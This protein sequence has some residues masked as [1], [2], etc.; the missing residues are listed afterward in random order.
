M[1]CIDGL[2]TIRMIR[3]KLKLSPDKQPVILLHSAS[4]D[5]ALHRQCDE[6]GV[7]FR[8][9]KPVKSNDLFSYLCNL[10]QPD[11]EIEKQEE[12]VQEVEASRTDH[13]AEKIKIL[14]AEDMAM[15]MLLVKAMLSRLVRNVD[16]IEA[17]NGVEAVEL[18]QTSAPDLVLMDV[19]MPELDGLEATRKIREIEERSGKHIPTIALSAGALKEEME[20]CYAAGMDDFLAKPVESEKMKTILDKHL[21]CRRKMAIAASVVDDEDKVHFGYSELAQM[22]GND[23]ASIREMIATAMT[24]VPVQMEQLEVACREVDPTKINASAHSIKGACL[25]L[26]CKPMAKLAGIMEIDARDDKLD[27]LEALLLEIKAEWEV[28]K[29]IMIQKTE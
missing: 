8:L 24:E 10:H 21:T 16:I 19:Q 3:E 18:Y 9:N 26:R 27:N 4:E 20:R 13:A 5:V 22:L 14:V 23:I 7:R 12:V 1:P 25:T 17:Q 29:K 11:K 15:N 6:M 2:E 28:V